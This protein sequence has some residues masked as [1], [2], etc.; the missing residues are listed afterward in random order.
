MASQFAV[1]A[2]RGSLSLFRITFAFALSF[3]ALTILVGVP[4]A[5]ARPLQSSI[6]VDAASGEVL[7]AS[8]ADTSTYPASLTKMMTLY[9]L[10]EAMQDGRV[11]LT[12]TITFSKYSAGMAATNLN[13][14]RGDRISVET[15]ILALVVRSA[16]DAATAIAEHL[17]GTETGFARLMTNKAQMLGMSRTTFRNANGLPDP[18]Q[19]TTARD[20]AT[21]SV[22]LIRDFPQYYGY[23]KRTSFKYRGVTYR[24]HNKL[25]KSFKGYDGIKTGYIRASGFNLASSAERDGR[26][27]VVVVLGGTSPS[28]RDRKVA[29]LLTSGFKTQRGTGTLIAAKA[30]QGGQVKAAA[31]APADTAAESVVEDV[32]ANILIK[33][34]QAASVE[35]GEKP[36]S[37]VKLAGLK[38]LAPLLKPGTRPEPKP[39]EAAIALAEPVLKPGT[40]PEVLKV[41]DAQPGAEPFVPDA[42][43][44]TVVWK[45][46]GNYGIQVGAYSKYNAAQ[47]AAQTATNAESQLLADARI[48][49]DT[50]KMN[51]GSKLY[52]ARVAG[53]SKTD[54]QT[55][56]R[57]LK[58]KRTDCLV[59]K[60]DPTLAMGN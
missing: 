27:L 44:T 16:N 40:G 35:E 10:F 42:Q 30:P 17:G 4:A 6:V 9:L 56:C 11:K 47:K 19:R 50:Q 34:A 7:S 1:K 54:A 21:L 31:A 22:A 18:K 38:G 13:V 49:I 36:F 39:A 2:R 14:D 12:D 26:R 23:F 25:L 8:N 24:G 51:N 20:M 43:S 55:A 15:A 32:I 29:D 48:I 46:D 60:I 33:P 58:A 59:L 41:A 57:N 45:A 3:A 37:A 5:E 53:L 52:R 28:M